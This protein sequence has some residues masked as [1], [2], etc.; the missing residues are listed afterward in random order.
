MKF[1]FLLLILFLVLLIIQKCQN[2]QTELNKVIYTLLRQSARWAVAAQQDKSPIIALLHANYAAGYLW[3]LKDIATDS[4]I[5]SA[6]NIDILPFTKKITDI[7]DMSTKKVSK[8]CPE[9]LEFID[10]ELATMGGDN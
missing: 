5:K 3:A 2:N 6:T 8:N 10:K 7:Q 4:Q 1:L 9:F